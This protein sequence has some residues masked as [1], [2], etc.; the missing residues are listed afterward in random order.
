MPVPLKLVSVAVVAFVNDQLF[1]MVTWLVA[2]E[3][4]ASP[5]A[6]V[7]KILPVPNELAL[8]KLVTWPPVLS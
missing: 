8:L 2:A 7:I 1:A 4:N 5:L 3:T 6:P